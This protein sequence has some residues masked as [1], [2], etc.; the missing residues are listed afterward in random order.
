MTLPHLPPSL[1]PHRETGSFPALMNTMTPLPCRSCGSP[2]SPP[3]TGTLYLNPPADEPRA[4]LAKYLADRNIAAAVPTAGVLQIELRPGLLARL[5]DDL[6]VAMSETEIQATRALLVETGVALTLTAFLNAQPLGTLLAA[7]RNR[8]LAE[9]IREE[10]LT[11]FFQPIMSAAEP[12]EVFAYECLTRG[13]THDGA[14]IPPNV[15]FGAA[16]S[17]DM[18]F[19][20]DRLARLT[21]IRSAVA[22]GVTGRLFINFNPSSI[23]TPSHCLRTTFQAAAAAGLEPSRIVFEV[24][25]SEEVG[26]AAHL[27]NILKVYR[28]A[29]FKVALDDVG[30]GYNSLNLLTQLRPDYVKLDMGLVRGVDADPYRAR[31]VG[32]LLE[33]ARELDVRTVVEGVE[34][35]G[36]WEWA[37]DHGA[38]FVQGYLFARPAAVPPT[39][40]RPAA[41]VRCG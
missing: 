5:A 10:R 12:G 31:V 36:E 4:A 20:L 2:P 27:L 13:L 23:Y 17:A 28:Q 18:L 38:D 8:W 29:G 26:D 30:A 33:M 7:T 35:V 14:M 39:P 22:R 15:L 34:T 3:E 21:A 24:V 37:R 16:R 9:V 1:V 41:A 40:V 6:I 11:T 32:K 19:S 25:E